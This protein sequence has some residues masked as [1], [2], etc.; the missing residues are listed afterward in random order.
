MGGIIDI[1]GLYSILLNELY[2][3]IEQQ[4]IAYIIYVR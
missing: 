1:V 3:S 2:K 4:Q